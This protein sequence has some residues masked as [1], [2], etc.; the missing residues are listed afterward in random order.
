[1]QMKKGGKQ[2]TETG[3]NLF[4]LFLLISLYVSLKLLSR[5][6]FPWDILGHQNVSF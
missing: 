1:M 2:E 6:L 4:L 3:S 5:K